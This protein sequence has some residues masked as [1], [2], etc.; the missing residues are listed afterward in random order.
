[1]TPNEQRKSER[2]LWEILTKQP[3]GKEH[4]LWR[5]YVIAND[6]EQVWESLEVERL[7]KEIEILGIRSS[8]PITGDLTKGGNET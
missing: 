3:K 8:V 1:M 7:D 2:L 6:I 4:Q 5:Q